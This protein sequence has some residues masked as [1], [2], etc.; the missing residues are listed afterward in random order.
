MQ[1]KIKIPGKESKE[2]KRNTSHRYTVSIVGEDNKSYSAEVV[3]PTRKL[4]FHKVK[5]NVEI[6]SNI[7]IRGVKK[8][9]KLTCSCVNVEDAHVSNIENL[10]GT[11]VIFRESLSSR[12][13]HVQKSIK[14]VRGEIV[15]VEP[16]IV[17]TP[18]GDD[19]LP[20]IDE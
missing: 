4:S 5:V 1:P 20:P 9:V 11:S 17:S 3:Y 12:S 16:Y 2:Q 8:A 13:K 7:K 14:S 10:V 15:S 19:D 6:G 18:P